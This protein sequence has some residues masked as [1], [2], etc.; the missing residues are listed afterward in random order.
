VSVLLTVGAP[1]LV[2]DFAVVI[3]AAAVAGYLAQRLGL[4]AIVGYVIAG[5]VVGPN[6]L[7]LIADDV[8]VEQM[9]EVGV[10]FLMFAIGL[11]LSGDQLRRTG[12]LMFGG[13]ALQVTATVVVVVV[14]CALFGV[15][16]ADGIFTGCLVALSS[17]AVVLKL[18]SSRGQTDSPTGEVAVAFL[19]FQDL[20]VV[21]MVLLVPM[22]GDEG[23][24]IGDIVVEG[25]KALIVIVAVLTLTRGVVPRVLGMVA[26]HTDEEEFLFAV[27][28]IAVGI[29]YLV[30]LFGLTASLGAFVAGLVVSSGAHRE[31]ARRYVMPFQ[32]VFAGVFFASVGMLLD[33][34]FVLDHVGEVLLFA[35]AVVVL[36]AVVV[37]G[38]ARAFRRPVPVAA[39]SSL[40]LAQ[41]GEFS[42]VLSTVGTAAGLSLAGR[43]ADGPQ[44]FVAVAVVLI[45]STPALLLVGERVAARLADRLAAKS[46]S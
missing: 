4:V 36:K 14:L 11:E 30:T 37:F 40:L 12:A 15:S 26:D 39:E 44:L 38:S 10:V 16:L 41:I 43:G 34:G 9:A 24:G 35:V 19:I 33:L 23:G 21:L 17:T 5:A 46:A 20:A 28:A 8:L 22:L 13:G 31:R 27:L 29:A 3:V 42:F 25:G 7:G 1:P 32:V 6:A 18:L 2:A 45:A